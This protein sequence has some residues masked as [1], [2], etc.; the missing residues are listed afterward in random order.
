MTN[1]GHLQE[2]KQ[3]GGVEY[4][5]FLSTSYVLTAK[6]AY[7]SISNRKRAASSIVKIRDLFCQVGLNWDVRDSFE[8]SGKNALF[9]SKVVVQPP[10]LYFVTRL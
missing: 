6:C 4:R 3:D 5:T 8:L 1:H 7:L 9:F 10:P 2:V